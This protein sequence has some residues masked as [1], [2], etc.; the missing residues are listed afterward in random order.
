MVRAGTVAGGLQKY[1]GKNC[2]INRLEELK[3][4][5]LYTGGVLFHVEYCIRQ[6]A[7]MS[8]DHNL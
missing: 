3:G 2:R 8:F 5:F 7:L 6:L 4:I 1:T